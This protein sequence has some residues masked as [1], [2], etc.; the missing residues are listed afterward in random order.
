MS[1]SA[2]EPITYYLPINFAN[3]LLDSIFLVARALLGRII[4]YKLNRRS[5]YTD[6]IRE[7]QHV[8]VTCITV[9]F[10]K[11]ASVH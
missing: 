11:P 9:E 4:G 6:E 3:L 8:E 7:I 10:L 1:S 5:N 2:S